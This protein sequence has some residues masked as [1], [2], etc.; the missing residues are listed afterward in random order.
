MNAWA[1]ELDSPV[2][3]GAMLIDQPDT[4][5]MANICRSYKYTEQPEEEGFTVYMSS[6]GE[7]IRFK[8]DETSTFVEVTTKDKPSSVKKKL[9]NIGFQKSSKGYERGSTI[10]KNKTFCIISSSPTTVYFS[11]TSNQ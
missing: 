8:K 4:K 11:K 6:E 3:L 1:I 10:L 7:K 2:Y 9:V 5:S